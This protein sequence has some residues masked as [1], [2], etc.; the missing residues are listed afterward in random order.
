MSWPVLLGLD[1]IG[2]NWV[3]YIDQ[4][5]DDILP[6]LL[7][8]HGDVIRKFAGATARGEWE[9]TGKSGISGHTHRAA[10]WC[11]K[12]YNGTARW[13]ETGC[14]CRFDVP[15]ANSPDWQQAVTIIEWSEDQKLMDVQQVLIRDGRALWN[16][17]EYGSV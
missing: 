1:E 2:W 16:G 5:R 10:E 3:D 11:H 17:V 13:I 12:D 8:K 9:K 6:K 15:G 4:P 14:T 7:V